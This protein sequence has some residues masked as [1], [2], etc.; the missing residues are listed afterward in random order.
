MTDGATI[1]LMLKRLAAYAFVSQLALKSAT[2]LG[3]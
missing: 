3:R 1:R 2:A